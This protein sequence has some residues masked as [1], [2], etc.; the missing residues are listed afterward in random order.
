MTTYNKTVCSR[1]FPINK[2]DEQLYRKIN[3]LKMTRDNYQL[4]LTLANTRINNCYDH[5]AYQ[6]LE[7]RIYELERSISFIKN[8]I[9]IANNDRERIGLNRINIF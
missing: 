4:D 7:Y 2:I 5:R 9:T 1:V 6:L 3:R 8:E